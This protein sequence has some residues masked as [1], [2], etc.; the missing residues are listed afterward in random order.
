MSW[1]SL[2]ITQLVLHANLIAHSTYSFIVSPKLKLLGSTSA[3]LA[4]MIRYPSGVD[5]SSGMM[6]LET[7][8]I[9]V[10][11]AI[12]SIPSTPSTYTV[13]ITFSNSAD[14]GSQFIKNSGQWVRVV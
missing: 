14:K 7:V 10:G 4:N 12:H 3:T 11:Y 1:Q 6:V 9:N 5:L 8:A 13:L 2:M